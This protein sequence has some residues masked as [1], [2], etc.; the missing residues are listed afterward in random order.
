VA[1]WLDNWRLRNRCGRV[2]K[3]RRSGAR[4]ARVTRAALTCRR[5]PVEHITLEG[6]DHGWPGAGGPFP[7]HD[8]TGLSANREVLRFFARFPP[9]PGS[10]G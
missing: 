4:G 5:A 8:P 2:E 3:V 7:K 1:K 10:H 6:T 9:V